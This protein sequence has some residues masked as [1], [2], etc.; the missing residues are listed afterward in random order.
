MKGKAIVEQIQKGN[1]V[2][3]DGLVTAGIRAHV[4]RRLSEEKKR[5]VAEQFALLDEDCDCDDDEDDDFDDDDFDNGEDEE[6]FDDD[7]ED[8]EEGLKASDHSRKTRKA[9][10][11]KVQRAAGKKIKEATLTE[12]TFKVL[13]SINSY[14]GYGRII[15]EFDEEPVGYIPRVQ[16]IPSP[17]AYSPTDIV[18]KWN[19]KNVI[20][21][22][23][24][25]KYYQVFEVPHDVKIYK[26]EDEAERVFI[27]SKKN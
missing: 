19:G 3:T 9:H 20:S 1:I 17:Y 7:D 23:T 5:L 24:K 16:D 6:D 27:A 4:L 18:Y 14:T 11:K 15:S 10:D 25:H 13:K 22:E 2:R 26:K 21:R 12:G 8:L